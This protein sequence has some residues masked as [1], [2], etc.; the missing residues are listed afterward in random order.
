[1]RVNSKNMTG[2][3]MDAATEMLY[4]L[5]RLQA[6]PS[7]A[8]LP[9]HAMALDFPQKSPLGARALRLTARQGARTFGVMC[10]PEDVLTRVGGMRCEVPGRLRDIGIVLVNYILHDVLPEQ[11]GDFLAALKDAMPDALFI[12]ADYTM[13]D[14]TGEQAAKLSTS[15]LEQRRMA[16]KTPSVYL[17]E[18]LQFTH[19]GLCA[20]MGGVHGRVHG[21]VLPA[22]RALVAGGSNLAW[23]PDL[24]E[25]WEDETPET[26][27]NPMPVMKQYVDEAR[28]PMTISG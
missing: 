13:L 7:R 19:A 6:S 17:A 11:R 8:A 23:T 18:H 10:E 14:L 27:S 28:S 24:Q 9:P 15:S 25:D 2:T 26:S 1:L 3:S 12:V 16:E 22:G 5:E 4:V 21:H 20:V